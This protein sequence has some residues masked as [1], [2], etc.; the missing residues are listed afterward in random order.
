LSLNSN[1]E[2]V[3]DFL[4]VFV[5]A[6]VHLTEKVICCARNGLDQ[7]WRQ[8]HLEI[9][10]ARGLRPPSHEAFRIAEG[11]IP[12]RGIGDGFVIHQLHHSLLIFRREQRK[13]CRRL[14]H[15]PNPFRTVI[16]VLVALVITVPVR[17][18]RSGVN[19]WAAFRFG[20]GEQ[21]LVLLLRRLIWVRA[22]NIFALEV[23]VAVSPRCSS[24]RIGAGAAH[25]PKLFQIP[26]D[27]APVVP[28]IHPVVFVF[29]E[30]L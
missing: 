14:A 18:R 19:G 17:Q 24:R 27:V 23:G 6:D 28:F 16:G 1:I 9:P 30:V 22:Q 4:N 5:F 21:R 15:S 29:I 10:G 20:C 26:R 11:R 13:H 3:R 8:K 7:I 2:C 12:L 25:R